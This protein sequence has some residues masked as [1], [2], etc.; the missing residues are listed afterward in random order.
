VQKATVFGEV[1]RGVNI[2]HTSLTLLI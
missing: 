2:L 1:K